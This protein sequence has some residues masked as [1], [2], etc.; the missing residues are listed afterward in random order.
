MLDSLR[1][2][3]LLQG[4]DLLRVGLNSSIGH[5][6]FEEFIGSDSESAFSRVKLYFVLSEGGES[7]LQVGCMIP[8][9]LAFNQHIVNIDFHVTADLI[10]ED[11]ID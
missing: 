1:G 7:L 4:L 2:I 5:H 9:P 10:L 6:K 11:F 8:R 3:H